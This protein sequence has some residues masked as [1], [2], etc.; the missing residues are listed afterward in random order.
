[1]DLITFLSQT[2]RNHTAVAVFADRLSKQLHL[3]AVRSDINAPTLARIFFDTVF[4]H[5]GLP[6]VIIL[7]W[8]P[9][10]TGSF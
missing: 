7:E 2:P 9:R 4:R 8:D 1:M 6:R 10:F 3:A 5:H